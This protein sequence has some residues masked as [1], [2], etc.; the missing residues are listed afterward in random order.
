MEDVEH[1]VHFS[2]RSIVLSGESRSGKTF[3]ARALSMS[4][5]AGLQTKLPLTSRRFV[6]I[7]NHEQLLGKEAMVHFTSCEGNVPLLV[8]DVLPGRILCH[9]R[10]NDLFW[11]SLARM[12]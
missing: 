6:E 11:E 8:D 9:G 2:N 12:R 3:F 10:F 4:L 1:D 5:A 7:K